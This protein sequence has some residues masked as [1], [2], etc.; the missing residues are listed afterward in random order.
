MFWHLPSHYFEVKTMSLLENH[1]MSGQPTLIIYKW[2][3]QIQNELNN[4]Q[5]L[6]KIY[7][8]N[9]NIVHAYIYRLHITHVTYL[10]WL[11]QSAL[12]RSVRLLTDRQLDQQDILP[13]WHFRDTIM[14][15]KHKSSTDSIPLVLTGMLKSKK[16]TLGKPPLWKK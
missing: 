16:I 3:N 7:L 6:H 1:H 10:Q 11:T 12:T 2:N 4:N 13:T 15:R 5:N 14:H 8:I 9:I